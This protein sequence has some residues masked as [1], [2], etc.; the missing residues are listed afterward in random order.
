M[1]S[2]VTGAVG[3]DESHEAQTAHAR[4]LGGN[5]AGDASVIAS[6]L[7]RV[8]EGYAAEL[9]YRR[10]VAWIACLIVAVLLVGA[11]VGIY[12]HRGRVA[13]LESRI[14]AARATAD[15]RARLIETHRVDLANARQLEV[16]L[17]GRLT[18]AREA[19]ES[20]EE[21]ATALQEQLRDLE[22]AVAALRAELEQ[23]RQ[24]SARGLPKAEERA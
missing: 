3:E 21:R 24:R 2:Q 5:V 16:D 1:G 6:A 4:T 8:R 9:R 18:L 11:V 23:E 12:L 14:A 15:E 13:A 7:D 10:L 19:T 17:R 20:A 22:A